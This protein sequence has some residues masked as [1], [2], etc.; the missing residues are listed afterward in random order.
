[1]SKLDK[2]VALQLRI[3]ETLLHKLDAL[4]AG[5][6]APS[7]APTLF[8]WLSTSLAGRQF[9]ADLATPGHKYRSLQVH[10][11]N[12]LQRRLYRDDIG[13][14]AGRKRKHDARVEVLTQAL[15][16]YAQHKGI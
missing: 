13:L 10:E 8:E 3:P 6:S 11:L 4:S 15:E 7:R 9:V 12:K 5:F 14:T 16:L 1:M 2:I